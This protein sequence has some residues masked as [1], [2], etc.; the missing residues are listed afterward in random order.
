MFIPV[1]NKQFRTNHLKH[2]NV[3]CSYC[4]EKKKNI[5]LHYKR[6]HPETIKHFIDCLKKGKMADLY[7]A[8]FFET[9]DESMHEGHKV[10][11]CYECKDGL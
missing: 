9:D 2:H 10:G 6:Y 11:G 1:G 7:G 8:A 3:T 5:N 4:G